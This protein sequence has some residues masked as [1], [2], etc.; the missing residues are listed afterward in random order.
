MSKSDYIPHPDNDLQIWHDRF[1]NNIVTQ[2]AV[3]GLSAE[4]IATINSDNEELHAK[5]SAVNAT[6]AAAHSAIA[7]KAASRGHIES[8]I[9]AMSRRIK[10]HPAYT[11]AMGSLLGIIGVEN[12]INFSTYK[13]ILSAIDQTGG[14]VLLKFNKYK[15]DGINIYCQREVDAE[16]I[17]LSRTLM[18]PFTDNRPLLVSGKPELRRY[19]AVYVTGDDEVGQFSDELVVN[20]AP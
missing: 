15:S 14:I 10:A 5:I 17:F 16:L 18:S 1:K 7:D 12:Q 4:D 3:L 2:Q 9:R 6:A 13:P 11:E 19:T 8:N 20:C